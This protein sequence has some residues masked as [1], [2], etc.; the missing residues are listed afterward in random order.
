VPA[1][2]YTATDANP[3]TVVESGY[4]TSEGVQTYTVTATDGAGNSGS[5]SVTYTVDNTAPVV[6]I[7]APVNGAHYNV[8]TVPSLAYTVD[9]LNP[10]T[11]VKDDILTTKGVH[12]VTVTAT[13]AAGN[14]GSDSATYTVGETKLTYTGATSGQYSDP[15]TVSATLTEVATGQPLKG[16]TITFTING[17]SA[18][19]TTDVNGIASTSITLNKAPGSYTVTASF[20]GDSDYTGSSV[21]EDFKITQENADITYTGTTFLMTSSTTSG[22]AT[23]TLA[24]TVR[25]ITAYNPTSD[26]DAGDIRNAIVKF[27]IDEALKGTP[28][29]LVNPS[30]TKT[31]T[32]TLLW[33]VDIGAASSQ[34]Y[35][36]RCEVNGYYTATPDTVVVTVSK[37][38]GTNFITGGGYVVLSNSAGQLA[39]DAGT[40]TNFGFN[41]KYN[42]G[43]TNLQ[44]NINIIFR[45]MEGGVLRVYQIKGNA[46]TSLT[47]NPTTGKATFFCKAN[48]K[49]ITNPLNPISIGG[50]GQL[51][52]TMTD[53]GEPGKSDTIGITYWN[54]NGGLWFS[55]SWSGTDTTEQLLRGGNLVVH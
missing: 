8:G 15:V 19:A 27:Y 13:D 22:K 37:P 51:K 20:A 48:L 10:Y 23:L 43:G 4:L 55:S 28:V 30:D 32:A 11:V 29:G 33:P 5:A 40:K 7:T 46:L 42:K 36:I 3:I 25:D 39:G 44:G 12:T 2:A 31:G 6:S 1:A 14:V 21:S 26:P 18:T 52:V 35:T 16:K 34:S 54:G 53:K 24:V 41:V 17:L 47:V 9:E 49:D 50:N 45:R 38:I